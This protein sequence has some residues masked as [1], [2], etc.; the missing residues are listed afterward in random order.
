MSA[1]V[2]LIYQDN[3]ITQNDDGVYH[4]HHMLAY[5]LNNVQTK[6]SITPFRKY[7]TRKT[8]AHTL[9]CCR[10]PPTFDGVH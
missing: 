6:K 8:L 5:I 4:P 10:S 2:A 1:A 7:D 3:C 9:L